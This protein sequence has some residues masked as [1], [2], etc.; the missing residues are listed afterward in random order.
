[1]LA[2]K[3]ELALAV[4]AFNAADL[5]AWGYRDVRTLPLLLDLRGASRRAKRGASRR[6]CGT[7]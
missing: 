4:S 6:I 7:A 5:T 2:D 1:M 3:A